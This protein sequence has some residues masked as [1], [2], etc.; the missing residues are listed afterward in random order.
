MMTSQLINTVWFYLWPCFC[1]TVHACTYIWIQP[2]HKLIKEA[3]EI[4]LSTLLG[5]HLTVNNDID[6]VDSILFADSDRFQLGHRPNYYDVYLIKRPR[7]VERKSIP[8]KK[9]AIINWW[10]SFGLYCNYIMGLFGLESIFNLR[11]YWQV[12]TLQII[13]SIKFEPSYENLVLN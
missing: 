9:K 5:L 8:E 11:L 10:L 7:F 13:N 6:P 4:V 1:I 2:G 12:F 3:D